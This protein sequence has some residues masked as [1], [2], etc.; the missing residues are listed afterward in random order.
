MKKKLFIFLAVALLGAAAAA[1]VIVW[2]AWTNA[3]PFDEI[4]LTGYSAV[5]PVQARAC[6]SAHRGAGLVPSDY[7][8]DESEEAAY[9]ATVE[10]LSSTKYIPLPSCLQMKEGGIVVE[11]G[12][13]CIGSEPI[14]WADGILWVATDLGDTWKPYLPLDGEDLDFKMCRLVDDY[15]YRLRKGY[16]EIHPLQ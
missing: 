1:G 11:A 6:V 9:R 14:Y 12:A 4:E 13:G 2:H 7:V 10:A 5:C 8:Y 3:L 16:V 15:G